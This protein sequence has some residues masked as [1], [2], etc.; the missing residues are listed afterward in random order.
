MCFCSVFRLLP[1]EECGEEESVENFAERVR[2]NMAEC[3]NVP[4]T[5]YTWSDK[6][7]LVKRLEEARKKEQQSEKI[8]P[9]T[10]CVCKFCKSFIE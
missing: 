7:D 4:L 10:M 2:G 5:E 3:L 6:Q 1:E 9:F 8:I